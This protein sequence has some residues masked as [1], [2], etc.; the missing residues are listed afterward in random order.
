MFSSFLAQEGQ[1]SRVL[2][3]GPVCGQ[4]IDFWLQRVRKLYVFDAYQHLFALP[5]N[6]MSGKAP[7]CRLD[8]P[9]A[10]FDG[11]LCWDL[12][13][14]LDDTEASNVV[15]QFRT[16]LRPKGVLSLFT[17]A[18][19]AMPSAQIRFGVENGF[20]LSWHPR[21]HPQIIRHYRPNRQILTL[22]NPLIPIKSLIYRNGLREFL[23]QRE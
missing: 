19:Q 9:E 18:E 11:I 1:D 4:N 10:G 20:R 21:H 12:C 8:F 14:L 23:F 17:F 7:W 5:R 6:P 22:L 16:L 3:V 13:D 15:Q 2:D